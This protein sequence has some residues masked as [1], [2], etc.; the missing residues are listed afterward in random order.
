MKFGTGDKFI[1]I[2]EYKAGFRTIK[3]GS[4]LKIL[5]IITEGEGVIM[6]DKYKVEL[7]RKDNSKIN[8]GINENTLNENYKKITSQKVKRL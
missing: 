1:C 8:G 5:T 6:G 3:K 7:I 2:E 4:K